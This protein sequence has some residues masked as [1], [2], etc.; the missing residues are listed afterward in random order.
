MAD[1]KKP[2]LVNGEPTGDFTA[3]GN[4]EHG[5]DGTFQE[6]GKITGVSEQPK[7]FS[8]L[9]ALKGLAAASNSKKTL[10]SLKGLAAQ[11]SPSLAAGNESQTVEQGEEVNALSEALDNANIDGDVG[12]EQVIDIKDVSSSYGV[13]LLPKAVNQLTGEEIS[14]FLSKIPELYDPLVEKASPRQQ[15]QILLAYSVVYQAEKAME[16]LSKK[17]KPVA[18][19]TKSE[20]D[21]FNEAHPFILGNQT[22]TA[23]DFVN[24]KEVQNSYYNLLKKLKDYQNAVANSDPV[25]AMQLQEKI[26]VLSGFK[27]TVAQYQSLKSKLDYQK[28][29]GSSVSN[30]QILS[31]KEKKDIEEMYNKAKEI[32]KHYENPNNPYTLTRKDN[33]YWGMG[34][35]PTEQSIKIN[36]SVDYINS[37]G[38]KEKAVVSKYTGGSTYLNDPLR[39]NTYNSGGSTHSDKENYTRQKFVE[40]CRNLTKILDNH[41]IPNDVWLRRGV[42]KL[43]IDNVNSEGRM[44]T[45]WENDAPEKL[46]GMTF[47]DTGFLSCGS[48]KN[49]GFENSVQMYIYCPK[50]TKALYVNKLSNFEGSNENETILQRGY[51]YKITRVYKKGSYGIALDCEV[52]LDSDADKAENLEE[53]ADKK[54]F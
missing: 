53:I 33:A 47:K 46:V 25:K 52:V 50:G 45:G 36:G 27:N 9:S 10:S 28:L 13:K 24:S 39:G 21:L 12:T 6:K 31:S 3:S 48:S 42:G 40:D 54:I 41:P 49:A 35:N 44:L 23:K 29:W 32:L 16:F 8:S 5:P 34:Y 17:E 22:I 43:K 14:K 30:N 15:R 4:N 19:P 20:L 37:L 7:K 18:V 1:E 26:N 11:N 38:F 51:T 2:T